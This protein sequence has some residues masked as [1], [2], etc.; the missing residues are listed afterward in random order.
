MTFPV[1]PFHDFTVTVLQRQ[2]DQDMLSWLNKLNEWGILEDLRETAMAAGTLSGF[3]VTSSGVY[4]ATLTYDATSRTVTLTPVGREFT[5]WVTGTPYTFTSPITS[6]AHGTSTNGYFFYFNEVGELV[7]STTPWSL[8]AH[9]PVAFLYYSAIKGDSIRFFEMHTARRNLVWHDHQHSTIGT[10]AGNPN[11][12]FILSSYALNT[13]TL[14]GVTFGASQGEVLDEDISLIAPALADGGPYDYWYRSGAAGEWIWTTGSATPYPVVS[15]AP[16]YNAISAGS[17]TLLPLSQTGSGEIV[18][19]FHCATT[20]ID[21]TKRNFFVVGQLNHANTT[22][23]GTESF[24]SMSFGPILPW[25]E[26]VPIHRVM[27]QTQAGWG[28]GSP[29]KAR[30]VQIDRLITSSRLR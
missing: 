5:V 2:R 20:A 22:V 8:F 15:G 7:V 10:R 19:I 17:W 24:S 27:I 23:A 14:A 26:V 16:A 30:I 25:Q 12:D 6:P 29:G 28:G 1:P 3:P 11:T 21:S 4:S 18:N 9:A 13:D